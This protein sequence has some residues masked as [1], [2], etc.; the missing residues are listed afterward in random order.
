MPATS[1]IDRAELRRF[2]PLE[3]HALRDAG[4][5]G[6][7]YGVYLE[8]GIIRDRGGRP[9]RFTADDFERMA[10]LGLF[11][12]D[13]YADRLELIDGE[14]YTMSRPKAPHGAVI[15]VLTRL[16]QVR[17]G[18]RALTRVQLPIRIDEENQP[19]PDLALVRLR[20][21]HYLVQQPSPTDTFLV[22]EVM[23][24]SV[25]RDREVKLPRYVGGGVPEVWLVNI[26]KGNVEVCRRPGDKAYLD[27][28]VFIPGLT[29]SPAAFPEAE[30]TVS[31][32]L[33]RTPAP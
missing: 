31:E 22:V 17:L 3:F 29:I 5:F 18:D 30:F 32:I 4:F 33:I 6:P 26:P 11:E 10:D 21:D 23:D 7:E 8:D 14:L 20:E 9:R 28:Q 12:G 19:Q 1:E 16:F 15:S 2:M 13:D 24:S 27:R 25:G